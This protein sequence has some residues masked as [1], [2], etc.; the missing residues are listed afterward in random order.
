MDF[1]L[2]S[3]DEIVLM[4]IGAQIPKFLVV[5]FRTAFSIL[6]EDEKK[7]IYDYFVLNVTLQD[8]GNREKKTREYIRK[9]KLYIITK[10]QRIVWGIFNANKREHLCVDS[11]LGVCMDAFYDYDNQSLFPSF[12]EYLER[13]RPVFGKVLV[14]SNRII[15]YELIQR[16]D[17]WLGGRA[18]ILRPEQF[19]T[20]YDLII[21]TDPQS[22]LTRS[23]PAIM[24]PVFK[25]G[26]HKRSEKS[27]YEALYILRQIEKT[28]TPN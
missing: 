4:M 23:I 14:Y 1:E 10:L 8:I 3:A 16:F 18:K 5:P 9:K 19:N 28:A 6:T 22:F 25:I 27:F 2:L 15:P 17:L 11:V 20:K 7:L 12:I 24:V 26:T 13:V 21:E